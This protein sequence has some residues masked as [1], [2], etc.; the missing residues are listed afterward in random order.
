LP[1]GP[2]WVQQTHLFADDAEPIDYFGCSVMISG[3][4]IVAGAYLDDTLA[5]IDAG[6]AYVFTRTS[7]TWSQQGHLFADDAVADDR[8]GISVAISGDT[9]VVGTPYD[10]VASE[11]NVGSAYVF[12]RSSEIWSQQGHL[13]ASDAASGDKFGSSV[14][15][16]GDTIVVGAVSDDTAAG[17]MAGSA[18]VFTRTAGIW[19]QE[20][21]LFAG[22]AMSTDLFGN[23]VAILGNTIVVGAKSDDTL[24]ANGAGSAYVFTRSGSTWTQQARLFADDADA[25]DEFGYA[26]AIS[27]ESVAVGARSDDVGS[28]VDAGSVYV[29][30]GSGSSWS[31]QDHL[32]ADDADA[33]DR[34]GESV[35]ISG[36]TL[37]VGAWM[38]DTDVGVDAGS[39]Y[40]FA[41][42]GGVWRQQGHVFA[43][44]AEA[45]Q[46]NVFGESV[47]VSGETIVV[48]TKS[49]NTDAGGQAGSAYVFLR[50]FLDF[51]VGEAP[52]RSFLQH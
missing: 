43:D 5:G 42:A 14:A 23:A 10:T 4:T 34:F 16:S 25:S 18:Y 8:F 32:F 24:S 46:M 36:D 7:E 6:S 49:D 11:S 45:G 40:V 19:S 20:D 1:D 39:A 44:E 15:I 9:V 3:D 51:Y 13:F 22:D 27:G 41:R 26:V 33:G 35:A 50:R 2:R 29:F 21:H 12:T 17:D 30:T 37:V 38:D 31:Q 48:G 47:S 52:A 28:N